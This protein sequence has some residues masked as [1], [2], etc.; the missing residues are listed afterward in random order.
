MLGSPSVP[1]IQLTNKS[2]IRRLLNADRDWSLFALADLDDGLFEHCD[3]WTVPD[4]LVLVFRA[5]SIRP[6]FVLGDVRPVRQLLAALPVGSGYLNLKSDQLAAAEGIFRYGKRHEMRRMILDT[7]EPRTGETEA[8][9]A[10]DCDEI[11]RLYSTGD[12]GGIAFAPYQLE[13][14]LFRGIRR[15]RELVAVAGVHVASREEGVA[16]LGNIFTRPDCR[17]QGLA[18]IA[19]SAVAL[20]VRRAGVETIG[21]NVETSNTAAIHAYEHIGFRTR[22]S[23]FE[24]PASRTDAV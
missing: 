23:Y 12:G 8:L 1:P 17:G 7:F 4:A 14:G 15:G 3:W 9:G 19:T 20:A 18:Q 22:F 16:A 21:L 13:T 10:V 6:I 2:E 5:I 11:E 24:G